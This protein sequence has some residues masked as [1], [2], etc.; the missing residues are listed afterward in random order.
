V[1]GLPPTTLPYPCR[2]FNTLQT[3]RALSNQPSSCSSPSAESQNVRQPSRTRLWRRT[4]AA[5]SARSAAPRWRLPAHTAVSP[6]SPATSFVAP[7]ALGSALRSLLRTNSPRSPRAA[8]AHLPTP[9]HGR[10]HVPR[11]RGTRHSR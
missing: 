6:T 3:S 2:R 8:S 11:P 10:R 4:A 7:V 1:Y 5:S 9:H